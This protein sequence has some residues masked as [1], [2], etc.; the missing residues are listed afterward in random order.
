MAATPA[1]PYISKEDREIYH[2]AHNCEYCIDTAGVQN[3]YVSTYCY[4]HHKH[5][6]GFK[7][8]PKDLCNNCP[9][10]KKKE[11]G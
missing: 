4:N 7:D 9:D 3:K 11:R 5:T 6:L 8:S 10:F 1:I 2:K